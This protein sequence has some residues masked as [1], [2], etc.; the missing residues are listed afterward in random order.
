MISKSKE[1]KMKTKELKAMSDKELK[2][3]ITQ[4]RT[5]LIKQYA[6]VSTGTIPKSPAKIKQ[7]RRNIAKIKTILNIKKT[8][9][10][11]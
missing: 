1:I 8:E 2:E 10:K 7:A 5:E 3:K 6:Q 4:L 11:K 9:V